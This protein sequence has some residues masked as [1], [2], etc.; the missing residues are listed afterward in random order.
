MTCTCPLCEEKF[1]NEYSLRRH[2]MWGHRGMKQCPVCGATPRQLLAHLFGKARYGD[3]EHAMWYFLLRT[4]SSGYVRLGSPAREL[5][6][7]G[8]QVAEERLGVMV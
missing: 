5:L 8:A 3:D 4:R 7:R 1:G 2:V 6:E